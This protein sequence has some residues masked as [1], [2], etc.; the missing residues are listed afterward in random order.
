[1]RALA[2]ATGVLLV[3]AAAGALAADAPEARAHGSCSSAAAES[4]SAKLDGTGRTVLGGR[5][6]SRDLAG[7][8]HAWPSSAATRRSCSTI[9]AKQTSRAA[10]GTEPAYSP[11]GRLATVVG[12]RV[13]VDG[14]ALADGRSPAW[15]PDGRS[16]VFASDR[17]GSWDLWRVPAR[18]ASRSGSRTN[19]RD[20]LLPGRLARRRPASRSRPATGSR[21]S[22]PVG[23]RPARRSH[24][25]LRA[26]RPGRRTARASSSRRGG[27]AG[28]TLAL[29][30]PAAA[31]CDAVSRAASPADARPAWG[32]LVQPA[33]KPEPAPK[34]DPN[35][36]LPD[37]DQRAPRGLVVGGGPGR[38]T[39]GFAS[40]VDNV[41][42]G[43]LWLAGRR[44]QPVRDA[45]GRRPADPAPQR[46]HA[47]RRATSAGCAT[48]GRRAALPL[49]PAS[50]STATSC[51]A[52][53]TSALVVARPQVRLL[54]RRP[55]RPRR[56]PRPAS[57]PPPSSA[58]AA[59]FE[60]RRG[61]ASSRA[62][63]V[64]WTDRYPA[65]FHGQNVALTDVPAGIYVLVH[66]ANPTG[67][68]R[69][70]TLANNAA[71]PGSGWPGRAGARSAPTVA[72][73]RLCEGSERCEVRR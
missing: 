1:M 18:E 67:R 56:A 53:R 7:R 46:R 43:P 2:A 48:R 35:E 54:P 58:T 9:A 64:G 5:H 59:Q 10:P 31:P 33:P 69:E 51:A 15:T 63:S 61:R 30:D 12:G 37:L 27:A 57:R 40:A 24:C 60:P 6:G 34:P 32:R 3:A 36:L 70:V 38:W 72:V 71:S 39:L 19:R 13:T 21:C 26:P 23:V 28:T 66:R 55:L 8:L 16:L 14:V 4:S 22:T 62:R 29:V 11:S 65:N 25:R 20:E 44:P 50:T 17:A 52:P 68:I 42:R 49:A 45:H 41:G 73:L 47:P